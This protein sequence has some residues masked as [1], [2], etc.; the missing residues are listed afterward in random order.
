M[1]IQ[2]LFQRTPFTGWN[3]NQL[4]IPKIEALSDEE[5]HELNEML[6]WKCFVVDSKG[7]RFG[8]PATKSKRASPQVIPDYRLAILQQRLPLSDKHVLEVGCFEGIHTIGL[9][10]VAKKVSAIDSRISNVVKT[11]VRCQFF[12]VQPEVFV[13]D[14]EK[15]N[16]QNLS[17]LRCDVLHHIGVLYH[18]VD[19]VEQIRLF[20]EYV[21]DAVLLDTHYA[22]EDMANASYETKLGVKK[23][24]RYT[25]GGYKDAFAGMH[26]HAKWLQLDDLV[27]ILKQTGFSQVE[28]IEKRQERNGP[29]VLIFAHR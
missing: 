5:L 6:D 27:D 13:F 4:S 3:K 26:G 15:M 23:Y 8:K 20:G 29:R 11:A 24:Y 2:T 16:T 25:E 7:R 19:P 17:A 22:T 21:K 10:Q 1:F 12:S 14:L 9:C 18:L 28:V